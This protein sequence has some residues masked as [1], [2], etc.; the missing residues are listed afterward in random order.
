L[1][2]NQVTILMTQNS[3]NNDSTVDVNWHDFHR[4]LNALGYIQIPN[5][6]SGK[7]TYYNEQKN[8]RFILM[9]EESYNRDYFHKLLSSHRIDPE[10]F[11]RIAFDR[12]H[13]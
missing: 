13:E 5:S 12:P 9:K 7:L 10:L 8:D 4:V 11:F 2:V 3:N 6:T 1:I